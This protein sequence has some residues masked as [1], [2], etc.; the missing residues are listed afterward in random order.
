MIQTSDFAARRRF[1]WLMS[2][3]TNRRGRGCF[4]GGTWHC[5]WNV[6]VGESSSHRYRYQTDED[7]SSITSRWLKYKFSNKMNHHFIMSLPVSE[8]KPRD[9]RSS[10]QQPPMTDKTKNWDTFWISINGASVENLYSVTQ[11]W[12][13]DTVQNGWLL[14]WWRWR[15]YGGG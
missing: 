10:K 4:I 5:H 13:H 2:R 7:G 9:E 12:L 14:T 1:S 8:D 6:R 15:W 11:I 3:S